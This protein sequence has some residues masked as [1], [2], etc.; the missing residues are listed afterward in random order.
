MPRTHIRILVLLLALLIP[1]TTVLALESARLGDF[2]IDLVGHESNAD[3]TDTFTYALTAVNANQGLEHW[4]LGIDTCVDYLVSPQDGSSYTTPTAIDGCAG[5]P[6]LCQE[7]AYDVTT[8]SDPVLNLN[9]I[10]F[11]DGT[12]QLTG[13]NTHIFQITV[14]ELAH[15]DRVIVGVKYG[16]NRPIAKIDGPI[17]G[18]GTAVSLASTGAHS[19]QI[20]A[21]LPVIVTAMAL[22]LG[23]TLFVWRREA[24]TSRSR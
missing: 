19:A 15:V 5:D 17:C 18:G 3:G 4:T 1:T 7:A 22:M 2:Q 9:G 11:G 13:S 12:P 14:E 24:V 23:L 20:G 16:P 10:K 6:Y 8:G 21:L